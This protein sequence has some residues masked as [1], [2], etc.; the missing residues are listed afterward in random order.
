MFILV[1]DSLD[2]ERNEALAGLVGF[3][4]VKVPASKPITRAQYES[5]NKLWPTQ[6]HE[7]KRYYFIKGS[8]F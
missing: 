2:L 6:F 1:T 4:E 8:D 5:A 7:N 3:N